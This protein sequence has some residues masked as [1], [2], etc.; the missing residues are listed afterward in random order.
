MKTVDLVVDTKS[1]SFTLESIEALLRAKGCKSPKKA[2]V[3]GMALM[4]IA[5]DGM[6]VPRYE[7]AKMSIVLTWED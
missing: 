6:E 5:G 1:F 4:G 3:R 7:I 2:S